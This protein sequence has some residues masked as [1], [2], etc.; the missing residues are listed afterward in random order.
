MAKRSHE[1]FGLVPHLTNQNIMK[2]K[3][4]CPHSISRTCLAQ[5]F[6]LVFSRFLGGTVLR[7]PS[8][9]SS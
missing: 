1:S 3:I 2:S 5:E 8:G 4:Q 6:G 7:F 9:A